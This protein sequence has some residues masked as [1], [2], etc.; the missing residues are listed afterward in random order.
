MEIKILGCSGSR[1]K[2]LKPTAFLVDE[3]LLI[4]AGTASEVLNEKE[5]AKID[6]IL[7]THSHIDHTGDLPFLAESAFDLRKKPITV[8]GI[9]EV[10]EAISSYIFNWQ[11]WPDFAEIPNRK[12]SKLSYRILRPLKKIKVGSNFITPIR[13]NHTVPTV[14]Y[15]IDNGKTAFAFI[16]DTY[17]TD[18]IWK[19]IRNNKRLHA[20]IIE[21]S[22]PNRLEK[23]AKL[24]GHLTPKLLHKEISKLG[25][26]GVQIYVTHL[27]PLYRDEI[28]SELKILSK[29]LPLKILEDGMTVKI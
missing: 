12:G 20:V 10:I 1:G 9:K 21:A 15:L 28:I 24:T 13:V 7:I 19:E 3:K 17:S 26:E 6:H 29:K 4:D 25:M 23:D 2:E 11:I 14:G 22:F 16:G 18:L 8:Y 27:K 5:R